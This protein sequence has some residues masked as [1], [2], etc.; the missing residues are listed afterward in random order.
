MLSEH[1]A[2]ESAD[3]IIISLL[4]DINFLNWINHFNIIDLF[5]FSFFPLTLE[6]HSSNLEL[7]GFNL[8]LETS[9]VPNQELPC[10]TWPLSSVHQQWIILFLLLHIDVE[11][12]LDILSHVQP[13]D[14]EIS[15]GN[16]SRI[17]GYLFRDIILC[18][19]FLKLLSRTD[20]RLFGK[21]WYC[22]QTVATRDIILVPRTEQHNFTETRRRIMRL[23]WDNGADLRIRNKVD[24]CQPSQKLILGLC[25][26]VCKMCSLNQILSWVC[27]QTSL[28]WLS[29]NLLQNYHFHSHSCSQTHLSFWTEI[30]YLYQDSSGR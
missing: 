24:C 2:V 1:S 25:K 11:R 26:W 15:S 29:T 22:R 6:P 4:L 9:K 17:T 13:T 16:R 5:F 20:R 3:N 27:V 10:C 7:D 8:E 30:K 28:I 19:E 12:F 14:W 21:S 23:L 18:K